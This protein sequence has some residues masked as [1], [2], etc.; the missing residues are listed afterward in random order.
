MEEHCG[1][2][3]KR[4]IEVFNTIFDMILSITIVVATGFYFALGVAVLLILM[5]WA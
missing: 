5:G 4:S 3:M 1:I 2:E